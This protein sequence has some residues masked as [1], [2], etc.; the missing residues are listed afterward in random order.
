M[1]S[2]PKKWIKTRNGA[3]YAWNERLAEAR[4][5]YVVSAQEAA[6][7]FRSVGAENELT[8]KYPPLEEIIEEAAEEA[9]VA[10]VRPQPQSRQTKARTARAKGKTKTKTK[11][12]PVTAPAIEDEPAPEAA[13]EAAPE[14]PQPV[15]APAA[16]MVM[17]DAPMS[18][19]E[20]KKAIEGLSD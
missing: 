7:Y 12:K 16:G 10:P 5:A 9:E 1:A 13:P 2:L 6:D 8:K 18:P 11:T 14:T 15:V 17:S 20:V 3:V 19:D 4:G